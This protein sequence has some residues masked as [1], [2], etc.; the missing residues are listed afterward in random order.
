MCS[1]AYILNTKPVFITILAMNVSDNIP[2]RGASLEINRNGPTK[3]NLLIPK[4]L[5]K[6]LSINVSIGN[7]FEKS[8]KFWVETPR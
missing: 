6:A 1:M 4:A 5:A 3:K 7:T 2:D 8:V